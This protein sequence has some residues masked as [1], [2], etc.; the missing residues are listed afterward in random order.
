MGRLTVLVENRL[1]VEREEVPA[2]SY[3]FKAIFGS[4]PWRCLQ[5]AAFVVVFVVVIVVVVIVVVVVVVVVTIVVISVASGN[6]YHNHYRHHA[7][8][9]V[10]E[11]AAT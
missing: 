8:A 4:L 6:P 3:H 7:G 11:A 10:P 2:A 1:D 9:S 5:V